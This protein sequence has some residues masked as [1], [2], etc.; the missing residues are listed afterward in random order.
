MFLHVFVQSAPPP[1]I[2]VQSVVFRHVTH[3]NSA[4]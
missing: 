3:S 4:Q 2:S 1:L